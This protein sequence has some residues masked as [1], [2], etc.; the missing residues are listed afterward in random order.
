LAWGGLL[1][2]RF[3]VS[4]E[5]MGGQVGHESD[6]AGLGVGGEPVP[7]LGGRDLG[8]GKRLLVAHKNTSPIDTGDGGSVGIILS[9]PGRVRRGEVGVAGRGATVARD[10]IEEQAGLTEP[11]EIEEVIRPGRGLAVGRGGVVGAAHGDGGMVPVR[12]SDDEI[13][14]EPSADL[15]DLDLLSAERMMGMG[16]GH[17]SRRGLGGGGSVLGASLASRI[18]SCRWRWF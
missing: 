3:L 7:D 12:E 8:D 11:V 18:A 5:E 17:E 9:R 14:I 1:V 10:A 6:G 2:G 15:D 4:G 13:G 16:D